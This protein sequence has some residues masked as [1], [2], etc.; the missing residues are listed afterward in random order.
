MSKILV[1]CR[2]PWGR[3]SAKNGIIPKAGEADRDGAVSTIRTPNVNAN[4]AFEAD[5]RRA[6]RPIEAQGEFAR[7]GPVTPAL[8]GAGLP[9][10]LYDIINLGSFHATPGTATCPS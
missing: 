3:V 7:K 6:P 9:I 1:A 8:P 2:R 4:R 10:L 5:F